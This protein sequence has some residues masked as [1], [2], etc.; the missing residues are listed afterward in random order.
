MSSSSHGGARDN[1]KR[2]PDDQRGGPRPGAGRP[3]NLHRNAA[4]LAAQIRRY[5][6]NAAER[7]AIREIVCEAIA[8]LEKPT[9]I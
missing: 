2:R 6:P 8:E 9:I 3:P 4:R 7:E 5:A 1:R